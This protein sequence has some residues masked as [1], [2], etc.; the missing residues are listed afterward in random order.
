MGKKADKDTVDRN[1][2]WR[3]RSARVICLLLLV[4]LTAC[5]KIRDERN[6]EIINEN[7]TGTS[8][9]RK[10]SGNQGGGEASPSQNASDAR[11]LALQIQRKLAGMTLE[12]KA[13]QLFIITP[14]ALTGYKTVTAAGQATYDALQKYPVGGLVYFGQ[15]IV[16]PEQLKE[17]PENIQG[18]AREI[19]GMPLFLAIDEEGGA[20]ARIGNNSNFTVKSYN[21]M[22]SVGAAQDSEKAY[23][24]GDTIGAYLENYGLNLDFAPDADVLTN[25][26]NTVIGNRSFG[27]DGK[28]VAEMSVRAAEGL[29][30]HSVLP[31]F[32]H[33]PGH[34]ATQGD[35]HE[36]FAY[37]D[38]TLEELWDN[39][40]LPFRAA[41]DLQI[42]FLMI[43]HISVPKVIGDNTP[44]S[45]SKIMVTDILR[46]RMGYQGIIITDSM[47]MGAVIDTYGSGEA[48]LEALQAGVDM[49]LMPQDFREAYEGVLDAVA[50][51]ILTE[52][53]IDESVVRILK[54]KLQMED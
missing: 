8:T 27:S 39:E 29:A 37:T 2:K 43:S 36:G 49:I 53:R 26:G 1:K 50:E 48:V 54:E 24:V 28:L 42:P 4:S 52:Q 38:K 25:P 10:E 6:D 16:N 46:E 5:G 22:A 12:E 21:D 11:E 9:G 14:E 3:G 13:A 18:Y 7:D 45:L 40:M 31:C 15:N 44:S 34:G 35:T 51:G 33:F 23:E 30:A 32:K 47:S 20:V 41:A 19:E 17:M